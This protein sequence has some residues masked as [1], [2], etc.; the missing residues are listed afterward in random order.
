M[1]AKRTAKKGDWKTI[2]MPEKNKTVQLNVG[3]T[4]EQME[5]IKYGF[6]PEE[7]ED[8]W[9]IYYIE[10]EENLYLHRSWTGFC[11]YVVKFKKI[12]GGCAAVSA[13]VNNE[14]EQYKSSASTE[15]EKRSCLGVMNA[16]L[17]GVYSDVGSPL[18]TW[19]LLGQQ[20][21]TPHSN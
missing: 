15:D 18:E 1:A 4:N 6:I 20:S 19:S 10:E 12:D 2:N 17:L 13:V 9:F 5:K 21:I 14:P 11:V 7:M 8:K 16:L 3:F